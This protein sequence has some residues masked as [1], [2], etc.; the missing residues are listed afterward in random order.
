[1]GVIVGLYSGSAQSNVK[2]R[3]ARLDSDVYVFKLEAMGIELELLECAR[4]LLQAGRIKHLLTYAHDGRFDKLMQLLP[5]LG[6]VPDSKLA[7]DSKP[8][9][10][11]IIAASWPR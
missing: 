3:L 5:T 4:D 8:G 11:G 7:Y 2:A 10:R 6:F 9:V 1:M